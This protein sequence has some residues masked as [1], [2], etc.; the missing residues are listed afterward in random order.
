MNPILQIAIGVAIGIKITVA[1][2]WVD[3]CFPYDYFA[4]KKQWRNKDN[5]IPKAPRKV[6]MP[7]C[8]PYKIETVDLITHEHISF[9]MFKGGM[10]TVP[11]SKAPAPKGP[12]RQ[13]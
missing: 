13:Y 9:E 10:H 11:P 4:N 3:R 8:K 1:Y 7:K 2:T 6:P 5:S 12:G